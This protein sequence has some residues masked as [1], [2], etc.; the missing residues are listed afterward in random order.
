MFHNQT[1]ITRGM[2]VRQ[3]RQTSLVIVLFQPVCATAASVKQE[4][5][6]NSRFMKL[7]DLGQPQTEENENGRKE[8]NL[9]KLATRGNWALGEAVSPLDENETLLA[10]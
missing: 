10:C 8:F 2:I 3:A 4:I 7:A 5:R 6:T 1:A 9:R